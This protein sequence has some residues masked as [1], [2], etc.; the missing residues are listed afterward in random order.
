GHRGGHGGGGGG[1]QGGVSAGFLSAGG[2]ITG[3]CNQS[4]GL[5]GVRGPG[6]ISAPTAA[7]HGPTGGDG[8]SGA[9]TDTRA[10]SGTSC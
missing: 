6:G 7:D 8:G 4:Q 5:G 10:C 3:A 1:G 2:T 9:A